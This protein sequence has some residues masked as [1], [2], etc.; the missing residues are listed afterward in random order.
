MIIHLLANLCSHV[1]QVNEDWICGVHACE[2]RETVF[3]EIEILPTVLDR[4][5]DLPLDRLRLL[6]T[7]SLLSVLS[8]SIQVCQHG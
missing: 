1:D 6:S 7:I 4:G 8:R 3:R 5:A 2:D